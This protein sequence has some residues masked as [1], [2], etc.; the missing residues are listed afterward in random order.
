LEEEAK[1]YEDLDAA[2]S[3]RFRVLPPFFLICYSGLGFP[4]SVANRRFVQRG[5]PE[6]TADTVASRLKRKFPDA[7]MRTI[8]SSFVPHLDGLST[9][10]KVV[11]ILPLRPSSEE[12]A[13]GYAPLFPS[14][15]PATTRQYELFNNKFVFTEPERKNDS[16][17]SNVRHYFVTEEPFPANRRS[18]ALVRMFEVK[19][20]PLMR[21]VA[22]LAS[23]LNEI[24]LR[25]IAFTRGGKHGDESMAEYSQWATQTLD[26]LMQHVSTTTIP[27]FIRQTFT[28]EEAK[29]S[30]RVPLILSRLCIATRAFIIAHNKEAVSPAR[31]AVHVRLCDQASEFLRLVA[32]SI[33]S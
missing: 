18:I 6:D 1:E 23:R 13:N 4:V 20:T 14:K 8:D 21:E 33:S 29:L 27:Q 28:G 9:A 16:S 17:V 31:V 24:E 25:V 26:A 22:F 12:E 11:T 19:Q 30:E 3:S 5:E 2:S 32:S 7:D 10:V 15:M